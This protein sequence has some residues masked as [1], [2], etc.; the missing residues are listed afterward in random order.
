MITSNAIYDADYGNKMTL[1]YLASFAYLCIIAVVIYY[2][3]DSLVMIALFAFCATTFFVYLARSWSYLAD[4]AYR[5]TMVS[6]PTYN[7][8]TDKIRSVL[9]RFIPPR[10]NAPQMHRN[11]HKVG[12]N[13]RNAGTAC[14]NMMANA[15]GKQIYFVQKGRSSF[16][17]SSFI[18]DPVDV[19]QESEVFFGDEFLAMI[20]VD[21]YVDM[22][23]YM[24]YFTPMAIYTC[25]PTEAIH[26]D[27]DDCATHHF[28]RDAMHVMTAQGYDCVHKLWRYSSDYVYA[29][30]WFFRYWYR[31]LYY[32][33]QTG[34]V[35]VI[36]VP[37][38]YQCRLNPFTSI[39]A[40][41]DSQIR[42]YRFNH[43]G[44]Q[45]E[46][47]AFKYWHPEHN[48]VISVA[49]AG[50]DAAEMSMTVRE[51]GRLVDQA[52]L[53]D[54]T[55]PSYYPNMLTGRNQL[56][57]MTLFAKD[58]VK[59]GY[60]IDVMCGALG[61]VPQI[62]GTEGECQCPHHTEHDCTNP[63]PHYILG[64]H[65]GVDRPTVTVATEP[66]LPDAVIAAPVRDKCA[67]EKAVEL[68]VKGPQKQAEERIA[69]V[70]T[71][72]RAEIFDLAITFATMIREKCGVDK[73]TPK[74]WDECVN[75]IQPKYR[76][77]MTTAFNEELSEE[78]HNVEPFIKAE[79]YDG[80]KDPRIIT[81]LHPRVQSRMYPYVYALHDALHG[82]PWFAFAQKPSAVADHLAALSTFATAQF[83]DVV[84]IE[85]DYSRYD[86]TITAFARE[87]ELAIYNTLFQG[88]NAA[89][90][91]WH[92]YTYNNF[93]NLNGVR[94]KTGNSRCSGAPD[95]C[96]MNSLLNMFAMF[97]ALGP[98]SFDFGVV[99]GDD[100]I[101]FM[102]Q[103]NVPLVE[104]AVRDLGFKL[105]I[106]QRKPGVPYT[107]L[108]RYFNW[109]SR[110][111]ICD[112]VRMLS[113]LHVIG[114][115]NLT[116][117][118][119]D[120]ILKAKLECLMVNDSNTPLVGDVLREM[121]SKVR[122]ARFTQAMQNRYNPNRWMVLSG[123]DTPW[124]NERQQWMEDCVSSKVTSI[125]GRLNK[126]KA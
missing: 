44:S 32:R 45:H 5:L 87:L 18:H 73:F 122:K 100:G 69:A 104:I 118:E 19:M 98:V 62:R 4:L 30:W 123:H 115:P 8:D 67:S 28:V 52:R 112:P 58:V 47:T 23:H 86:G 35:M 42:R 110:N 34:R 65:N 114:T 103:P 60:D 53:L 15:L 82:Q 81:P 9:D 21:Y 10:L 2:F 99:G 88:C 54:R 106:M 20:N 72:R 124:P 51:F 101:F 119:A 85:T 41:Y 84:A 36:L 126:V 105:K 97:C 78:C 91:Q 109:G 117:K 107:F 89:I 94:Y 64:P 3:S 22:A 116:P 55:P 80:R 25:Q 7:T 93:A 79:V 71:V 16:N 17:G 121:Y 14:A 75:R 29:D 102:P 92:P 77:L 70:P 56:E 12:A 68:R 61:Y 46:W 66:V 96:V 113:K 63:D 43:R 90:A 13:V 6:S 38:H 1:A 95:T 27:G 26:N 57:L 111:S 74:A 108:A 83:S 11:A 125:G 37:H 39:C 49:A 50:P 33:L 76:E 40:R 120:G 59:F 31:V 48:Q 24:S